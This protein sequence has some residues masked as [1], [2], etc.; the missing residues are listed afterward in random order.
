MA[1]ALASPSIGNDQG[2]ECPERGD[3]AV[4]LA[5]IDVLSSRTRTVGSPEP[6]T[7]PC[8]RAYWQR[9]HS[10]GVDR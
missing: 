3:L 4:S 1:Q 2:C 8:V 10:A 5:L 9:R 7:S 6:V